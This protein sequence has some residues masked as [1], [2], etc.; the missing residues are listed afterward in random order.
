[1]A[2]VLGSMPTGVTFCCRILILF[3]RSDACD[4]N[5]A[6]IAKFDYFV[7]NSNKPKP[8]L[9]LINMSL[10]ICGSGQGDEGGKPG[11]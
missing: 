11:L 6:I 7:K 1:M 8:F 4:A 9:L 3:S 10:K 5:I 2:E